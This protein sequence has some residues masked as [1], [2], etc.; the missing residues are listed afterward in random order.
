MN[1]QKANYLLIS[2]LAVLCLII[3][4]GLAIQRARENNNIQASNQAADQHL[5]EIAINTST[6]IGVVSTSTIAQ[7]NQSI[8]TENKNSTDQPK[9]TAT[10]T[11]KSKVT[12]PGLPNTGG[13]LDS[14]DNAMVNASVPT[15]NTNTRPAGE[16]YVFVKPDNYYKVPGSTVIFTGNHFTPNETI[17]VYSAGS[18]MGTIAANSAGSFTTAAMSIPYSSGTRTFV[19]SGDISNIPFPVTLTVGPAKP[20]ITLNTYYAGQGSLLTIVGHAFGSNEMVSVRF[21]GV[22]LGTAGT[23]SQGNFM[24]STAVPAGGSGQKVVEAIGLSTGISDTEIF[25]QAF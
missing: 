25:S 13:S 5:S 7:E 23:D 8:H 18:V 12:I 20:W 6:S 16:Y 1:N 17:T 24:L 21:A 10:A 2:T 14:G 9:S 11:A 19:F 3:I 4:G 22:A 15:N